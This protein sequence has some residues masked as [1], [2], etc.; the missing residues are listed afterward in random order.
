MRRASATVCS[1]GLRASPAMRA[2]LSFEN[3]RPRRMS[4][5]PLSAAAS[6]MCVLTLDP[7]GLT[8]GL[9]KGEHCPR[10]GPDRPKRLTKEPGSSPG[11]RRTKPV[12]LIHDWIHGWISPLEPDSTMQQSHVAGRCYWRFD[13]Y[14]RRVANWG[15]GIDTTGKATRGIR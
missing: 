2:A 7:L 9:R 5:G 14:Y 15:V 1:L 10:R 6:V 13:V 3:S 8:S 12:R 11:T 4:P